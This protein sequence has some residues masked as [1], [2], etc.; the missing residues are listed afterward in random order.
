MAKEDAQTKVLKQIKSIRDICAGD[1]VDFLREDPVRDYLTNPTAAKIYD[2]DS[3]RRLITLVYIIDT[4]NKDGTGSNPVMIEECIPYS[5]L[6]VKDGNLVVRRG[7][8]LSFPKTTDIDNVAAQNLFNSLVGKVY[9]E[10][11]GNVYPS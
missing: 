11:K 10:S 5:Q 6:K 7:F 3:E 1:C 9:T 4:E 2:K 8:Q